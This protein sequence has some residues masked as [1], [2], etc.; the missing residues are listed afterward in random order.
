MKATRAIGAGRYDQ[1]I[2]LYESV[3]ERDPEDI[4]A[5][6]MLAQCY[7]WKGDTAIALHH[8]VRQ[9]SRVPEDIDTLLI[10]ARCAMAQGDE[11]L[12][13]HFACRVTEVPEKP[14]FE[15]PSWMFAMIKPIELIPR[16]RGFR[17][18]VEQGVT[19]H[20]NQMTRGREWAEAYR[21]TYEAAYGTNGA[22]SS[23]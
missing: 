3:L 1:A 17:R 13:Y 10:A 4:F 5:S 14:E 19:K 20:R 15:M 22:S 7:E 9:L 18:R 8:A 2:A 12:T 11:Q 6:A 23:H 21:R 16:F